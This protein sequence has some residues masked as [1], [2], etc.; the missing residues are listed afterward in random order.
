M[1]WK[2]SLLFLWL[3]LAVSVAACAGGISGD[4][5][6]KQTRLLV[7]AAISLKDAFDEVKKEFES[8][9]R[10]I[11]IA[12]NFASSGA[13]Q[14]Q[15]EQ[16]AAVDVFASAG[17]AQMNSLEQKGLLL[18]GTRRAFARNTAVLVV[19]RE[20]GQPISSFSDLTKPEIK[21]IAIGNPSSVPAGEYAKQILESVGVWNDIQT[22]IV[23]AE[24]V[25]QVLT[26]VE[27]GNVE[28]G[29]VYGT[30]AATSEKVRVA[31]NAPAGSSKP[32][33]YPVAVIASTKSPKEARAL[34]DFITGE[35]GRA[36]LS[37]YGFLTPAEAAS[38][39][40]R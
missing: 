34:V 31:A 33:S 14:L 22:K 16:G 13:L 27:Q 26:Y 6:P 2:R 30:D 4:V 11:N 35:K 37:K 9:N 28:A 36:I 18:E 8:E 23:L 38:G 21:H 10:S 17:E 39:A 1:V 25:R 40:E 12:Y 32:I 3:V 19:P 29:I 20:G 15:I 7:S 24:N 5:T